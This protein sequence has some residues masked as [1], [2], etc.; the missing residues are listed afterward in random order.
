MLGQLKMDTVKPHV[1]KRFATDEEILEDFDKLLESSYA[2][3]A[4]F[5]EPG[6]KILI[7]VNDHMRSTPTAH[8]MEYM[9]RYLEGRG[10]K[11]TDLDITVEIASG[12]HQPPK[13]DAIKG[14]LG[15]YY[16]RFGPKVIIHNAKDD[17]I[18]VYV[19][20]SAMG[21]PIWIDKRVI[22]ADRILTI[23]S[24]EPH[25][26][27]GYTGARKSIIPGVSHYR[28]CEANHKYALTAESKTLALKGN[29]VHDD[30]IDIVERVIKFIKGDIVAVN[31]VETEAKIVALRAGDIFAV[32]DALVPVANQL[33]TMP[34]KG[35]YDIVVAETSKAMEKNLHQ[36]LKSFENT[37]IALREGGVM[38]LVATCNE[39]LGPDKFYRLIK[40]APTPEEVVASVKKKYTLGAHKTTNLLDFVGNHKMFIVSQLD[41]DVVRELHCTPFESVDAALD[42]AVKELGM[43]EP[44]ILK[45]V[46]AS[47]AAPLV[48]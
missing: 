6:K 19:E 21:T 12:T 48:E 8:I 34:V 10:I 41:D 14:I 1:P 30:M 15:R 47:N 44:R 29:A 31:V 39:G 3:L 22:E 20:D 9:D 28:T 16:E 45:V 33:Y 4:S 42:A 35:V 17:D 38:I 11:F 5:L 2:N 36:S 27:A 23:N 7:I 18:H 25:Y 37:K 13:D 26:F 46:Q 24:V 43:P 40:S 32:M